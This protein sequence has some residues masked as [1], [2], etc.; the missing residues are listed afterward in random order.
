M[1][2]EMCQG[3]SHKFWGRK[4]LF[5]RRILSPYFSYPSLKKSGEHLFLTHNPC[6]HEHLNS[7]IIFSKEIIL[8][9]ALLL[10]LSPTQRSSSSPIRTN[11]RILEDDVWSSE[12]FVCSELPDVK[13]MDIDYVWKLFEKL[14]TKQ[15]NVYVVGYCLEENQSRLFHCK[16][17]KVIP[18]QFSLMLLFFAPSSKNWK[19]SLQY[20]GFSADGT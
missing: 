2:N 13:V 19:T 10:G 16:I 14:L 3:A 5:S 8:E 6:T 7:I 18:F 17:T 1:K 11:L 4:V 9:M 12:D 20:P 15:I